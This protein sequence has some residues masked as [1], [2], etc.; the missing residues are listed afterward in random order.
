V[1]EAIALPHG[2]EK[3]L[4]EL[5]QEPVVERKG[6]SRQLSLP[7]A[8]ID[9]TDT[10]EPQGSHVAL[11]ARDVDLSKQER[12]LQGRGVTVFS[13]NRYDCVIML[14]TDRPSIDG[15]EFPT[16]ARALAGALLQSHGGYA[17]SLYAFHQRP[18]CAAGG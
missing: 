9:A 2:F 17:G 4:A 3:G 12:Q 13:P 14:L 15:H 6:C 1:F 8:H 10:M 11:H 16:V 18:G 5:A 7:L